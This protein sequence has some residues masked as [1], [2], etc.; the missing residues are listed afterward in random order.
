MEV[1]EVLQRQIMVLVAGVVLVR[2][3]EMERV[4]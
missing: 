1:L 4:P 3:V 2:L